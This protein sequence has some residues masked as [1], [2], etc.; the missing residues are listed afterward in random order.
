[1]NY[2]TSILSIIR[3]PAFPFAVSALDGVLCRVLWNRFMTPV[4]F[5]S[6][7]SKVTAIAGALIINLVIVAVFYFL[8]KVKGNDSIHEDDKE[9]RDMNFLGIILI[10]LAILFV[11]WII[12]LFMR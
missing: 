8:L 2:I 9:V 7:I 12:H 1:M 11:A 3:V 10:P 5:L 4:E 6:E